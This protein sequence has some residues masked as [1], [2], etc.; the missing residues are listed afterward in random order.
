MS[1][2]N[3]VAS[4]LTAFMLLPLIGRGAPLQIGMLHMPPYYVL[5]N[6]SRVMGGILTDMLTKIMQRAGI[7][8]EVK[9]YPAKR[10]YAGV[11]DGTV[12]LW[13]GTMGVAEFEGK[14]LV[15]P[16]PTAEIVLEIYSTLPTTEIPKSIEGLANKSVIAIR[17]FTYGGGIK[18][19]EDPAMNIKVNPTNSH[20]AAFEMLVN[21]RAPF[22]LDYKQPSIEAIERLG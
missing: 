8:Y 4:A 20:D 10:L 9:G 5:E 13:L 18:T 17:G 6:Q 21:G 3:I 15:S 22:V 12:Q 7:E 11:A 16:R 1:L 2:K 19:L 14:V